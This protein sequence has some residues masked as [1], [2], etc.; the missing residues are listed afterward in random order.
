MHNGLKGT[1]K[2]ST[3]ISYKTY[4]ILLMVVLQSGIH[5]GPLNWTERKRRAVRSPRP[6]L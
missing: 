2:L 6:R 3:V 5:A 1:W 4:N